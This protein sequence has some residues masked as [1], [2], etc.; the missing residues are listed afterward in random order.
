MPWFGYTSLEPNQ[1]C[2]LNLSRLDDRRRQVTVTPE[3]FSNSS[4][5]SCVH[6]LFPVPFLGTAKT[7]PPANLQTLGMSAIP[8]NSSAVV[9]SRDEQAQLFLGP[10]SAPSAW[11]VV[12]DP[13]WGG[14]IARWVAETKRD[15]VRRFERT[16]IDWVLHVTKCHFHLPL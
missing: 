16:V 9:T 10:G 4:P 13:S 1:S 15:S 6:T 3:T 12:W 14:R 2:N 8:L 7:D 5:L 11:F